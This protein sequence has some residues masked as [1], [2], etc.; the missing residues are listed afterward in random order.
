MVFNQNNTK[1]QVAQVILINNFGSVL[2]TAIR[3]EKNNAAHAFIS[4]THHF[5]DI[6]NNLNRINF[7]INY[8]DRNKYFEH[9]INF[10][11]RLN[12]DI[13]S[14]FRTKQYK[15]N[16]K[17]SP[18]RKN[19]PAFFCVIPFDK[20][21]FVE[22]HVNNLTGN[23]A[24]C[25]SYDKNVKIV[26]M[27]KTTASHVQICIWATAN[28]INCRTG[29]AILVNKHI[30][31]SEAYLGFYCYNSGSEDISFENWIKKVGRNIKDS[32]CNE[33]HMALVT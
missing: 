13:W 7:F 3:F 15:V 9:S 22:G 28:G 6:K 23:P 30:G 12:F 16:I 10:N 29:P 33:I 21:L 25:H 8:A 32:M 2:Y 24:Y 17:I 14:L 27:G 5:M 26:E 31:G 18:E 11:K 1:D 20:D 19:A 4:Y